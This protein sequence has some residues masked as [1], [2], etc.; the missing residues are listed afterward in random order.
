MASGAVM[1]W[2]I[3][4]LL[5]TFTFQK[6]KNAIIW[7]VLYL[8]LTIFSGIIDNRIQSLGNVI[9]Q[10]ISVFFFTVNIVV[11][12]TIVFILFYYF[13]S[14][15]EKLKISL[16][17]EKKKSDDLLLNILPESIANRL[18]S[19]QETIADGFSFTTILFADIVG[20]TQL[21]QDTSPSQLVDLLNKVF[22]LFDGLTDYYNL[23][24]IKTIGDAY[25]VAAGLPLPQKD[26]AIAIAHMAL[27]MKTLLKKFNKEYNQN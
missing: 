21:S 2:A 5:G 16:E 24:K 8:I 15:G 27:D 13:V 25:M 3:L 4:S 1:L 12:S 10:S 22:S 19:T 9:P 23:E 18:K 11:I 6:S 17:K 26:H 14:S 20:F 7:L